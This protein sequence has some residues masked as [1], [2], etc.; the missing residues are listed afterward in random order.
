[1]QMLEK[2]TQ[3]E[4][5][6]LAITMALMLG[7][8]VWYGFL[9]GFISDYQVV[10]LELDDMR[11][12]LAKQRRTLSRAERIEKDFEKIAQSL[13]TSGTGRRPD[14]VFSEEME[15]LFRSLRLPVPEFGKN[16]VEEIPDVDGF[17]FLVL[18]INRIRGDLDTIAELLKSFSE[19]NLVLRTLEIKSVGPPLKRYLEMNAE[20]AQV[21]RTEDMKDED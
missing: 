20:L 19:R 17:S 3:R 13:P 6:I 12:K 5:T 1:M 10:T 9:E 11:V 21:V 4:K 15:A 18:P 2:M 8:G 16:K 14:K 7:V